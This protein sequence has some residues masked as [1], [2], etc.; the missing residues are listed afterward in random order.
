MLLKFDPDNKR[1]STLIIGI[2]EI[3][4]IFLGTSY[5]S[6]EVHAINN[7][8][9]ITYSLIEIPIAWCAVNGSPAASNP[10]IPNPSGGFDTTTEDVLDRRL[11][12]INNNIYMEQ[13]GIKFVSNIINNSE[14]VGYPIID[15]QNTTVGRLGDV[16]IESRGMQEYVNTID[17][18]KRAWYNRSGGEIFEGIPVVNVNLFIND[19]GGIIGTGGIGECAEDPSNCGTT[20]HTGSV[21]IVDNF[22]TVPGLTSLPSKFDPC[23]HSTWNFWNKDPFDQMFGHELGHSLSLDHNEDDGSLMKVCQQFNGPERTINNI[24]LNKSEI[25]LIRDVALTVTG[26]RISN[27]SMS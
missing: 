22:Y 9:K 16:I 20:P 18:C 14:N 5:F 25:D 26:A 1:F 21:V 19:D 27:S 8:T 3:S 17:D 23:T 2:I 10:N 11:E 24:G 15:D 6:N 12:R 4:L 7:E 13:A